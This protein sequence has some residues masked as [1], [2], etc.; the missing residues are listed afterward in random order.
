MDNFKV[1]S[2]NTEGLSPIK[3]DLLADLNTNI[4][5]LQET[6]KDTAPPAIP[7]MHLIIHHGSRVHGTNPLS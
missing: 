4:L 2:F 1:T 7:G 3:T 6:H 5:C